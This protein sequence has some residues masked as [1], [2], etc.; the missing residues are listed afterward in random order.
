M[1]VAPRVDLT[2]DHLAAVPGEPVTFTLEVF[3]PSEIIEGFR[4]IL[5]GLPAEAVT[6]APEHLNLFPGETGTMTFTVVL[7][8]TFPAGPHAIGVEVETETAP[9]GRW[10][11]VLNLDVAAVPAAGLRVDPAALTGGR[12]VETAAIL[13]NLG[14]DQREFVLTGADPEHATLVDVSPGRVRLGPGLTSSSRVSI[15][16]GRHLVGSPILRLVTVTAFD[17]TVALEAPVSF[18]Q[19]PLIPRTLLTALAVLALL[20]LWAG[21]LLFGLGQIVEANRPETEEV[22]AIPTGTISGQVFA[23]D[24]RLLAGITV[25]AFDESDATAAV[26]AAS[27]A[28]DGRYTLTELPAGAYFVRFSSDGRTDYWYDGAPTT[29]G[30]ERVLLAPTG[31]EVFGRELGGDARGVDAVLDLEGAIAGRAADAD[32][33][34]L[35]GIGVTVSLADAEDPEAPPLARRAFEFPLFRVAGLPSPAVL[36]VAVS[37]VG[38]ADTVRRVPLFAGEAAEL[39]DVELQ[40]GPGA[41]AGAVTDSAGQGVASVDIVVS[42]G[43]TAARIETDATGAFAIDG[44]HAPRSYKLTFAEPAYQTQTALVDVALDAPTDDVAVVL[45]GGSGTIFGSVWGGDGAVGDV[46]V[47]IAG[48]ET[49]VETTTGTEKENL[50]EFLVTGLPT[51]NVYTVTF[52]KDGLKP[53]VVIVELNP[54]DPPVEVVVEPEVDVAA[55]IAAGEAE[56]GAIFGLVTDIDGEPI[57]GVTVAITDG[58]TEAMTMTSDAPPGRYEVAG[59]ET[60]GTFTVTFTAEGFATRRVLTDLEIGQQLELNVALTREGPLPVSVLVLSVDGI[61]PFPFGSDGAEVL[62]S[63][64]ETFGEGEVVVG[65]T[66]VCPAESVRHVRFGALLVIL[67]TGDGGDETFVGYRVDAQPEATPADELATVSGLAIRQTVKEL[68]GRFEG[69]GIEVRF[70]EIGDP[71]K[72]FYELR[73]TSD[74]MLLLWGPV[75][76]ADSNGVVEDDDLVEGIY[77]PDPCTG[78]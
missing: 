43:V 17:G 20:A 33:R 10:T 18:T 53:T 74:D 31:I 63:F 24:T 32:G 40:E 44:L 11:G 25:E 34:G 48:G 71:P 9:V 70:V 28:A 62:A 56:P 16:A 58:E 57:A 72:D 19:K 23:G 61:G 78:G 60:A 76:D 2:P 22:V 45:A 67:L 12:Q 50:G 49:M 55:A 75:T 6:A 8:P 69:G 35:T 13:S 46:T 29:V 1:A 15:R 65:P 3:N 36:E 7:P 14:N 52:E 21:I 51:P 42:D 26:S 39:G 30:A 64:T 5:R 59:F 4:V 47:T 37:K 68:K 27:T 41:I 54:G 77:A 73:R 38:F 66:G